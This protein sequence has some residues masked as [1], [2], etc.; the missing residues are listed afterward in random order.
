MK[1]DV[2]MAHPVLYISPDTA[3]LIYV[4]G[5]MAGE[6]GADAPLVIPVA[7]QG[8]LYIE[9]HPLRAGYQP[10]S[11]RLNLTGGYIAPGS[12]P[13]EDMY[14]IAWPDSVI[15][16]QISPRRTGALGGARRLQAGE[17]EVFLMPD[18]PCEACVARG[19]VLMSARL[20]A[21]AAGVRAL[22]AGEGR[23]MLLGR[24]EAG[25]FAQILA[26]ESGETLL[27]VTGSAISPAGQGGVRVERA[28]GDEAGHEAVEL[29][30]PGPRAYECGA[31]QVRLAAPVRPATPQSAALMLGQAVLLDQDEEAR[32]L[33]SEGAQSRYQE[34]RALIRRYDACCALRYG[35][36]ANAVGL[37][38]LVAPGY[39]RV[40]AMEYAASAAPGGWRIDDLRI[41]GAG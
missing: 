22:A 11:R 25:E 8:A 20:P 38:K 21:G 3:G 39:A 7:P 4:N 12:E 18:A 33:L 34:M 17:Y 5:H 37:M 6:C 30:S 24:C 2:R 19:E 27:N 14:I 23:V 36:R 10:V 26:P 31:A 35:A 40:H 41:P 32:A 29:W 28:L 1:G 16:V 9:Y 15:D 13:P